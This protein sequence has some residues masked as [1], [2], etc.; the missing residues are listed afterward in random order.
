MHRP[1]YE[2]PDYMNMEKK[3]QRHPLKP[4]LPH[5]AKL[6]MLGTFPPDKKRWSMD[7]FYPNF[8]ND[9]WRIFGLAFFNDKDFF[10][11]PQK[12]SFDKIKIESFLREKGIAI[13][14]TAE[15]AIRLN[16]NASDKYLQITK[17]ADIAKIT[18]TLKNCSAIACT[19]TKAAETLAQIAACETPPQGECTI[20]SI[21]GKT[22]KFYRMPSSSRAYPK[23]LAE[24]AQAYAKMFAEVGLS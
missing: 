20:C 7:F 10:A 16:E 6:L 22:Y 17:P 3:T 14:D 24:K 4:F 15:E 19:G 5:N 1:Q 8:Q 13:F 21:N 18:A 12:R 9:M 23:S 11:I 2:S